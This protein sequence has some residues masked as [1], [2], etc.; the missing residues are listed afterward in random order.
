MKATVEHFVFLERLILCAAVEVVVV[1]VVMND[2]NM[3]FC[4]FFVFAFY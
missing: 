2:L 1:F 4:P 3:K